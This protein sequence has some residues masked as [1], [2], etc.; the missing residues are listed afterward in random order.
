M[1]SSKAGGLCATVHLSPHATSQQASVAKGLL[2]SIDHVEEAILVLLLLVDL[3]DGRRDA[4]HA[5]LVHQQEESL[6]GIQLQA[7]PVGARAG[8]PGSAPVGQAL[9]Q[10]GPPPPAVLLLRPQSRDLLPPAPDTVSEP[11]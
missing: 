7:T 5:V 6:G 11:S 4:H 8:G 10:R 3:R 2:G 9:G 1:S